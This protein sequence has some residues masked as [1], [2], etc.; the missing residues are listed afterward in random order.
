MAVDY[1]TL[2]YGPSRGVPQYAIE[3]SIRAHE[4][5]MVSFKKAW[6]AGVLIGVGTDAG[7]AYNPHYATYMEFVTMV[8][9]GLTPMEALIAG[10]INSAKIAGVESWNG[11]ITAGKKANFLVLDE[12]PLDN[13]WAL[14]NVGQ[15]Y[16]GGKLV[17][18]PD[19]EYLPHID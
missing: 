13:I 17:V 1:F 14:K 8:E 12:N 15:V 18:L 10:T 11:S 2:K 5:Q 6:K 7:T 19:V 16:L 9:M 3:K 4:A